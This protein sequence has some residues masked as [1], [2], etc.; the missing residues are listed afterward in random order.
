ME[1]NNTVE[2]NNKV[3]NY[4]RG[5]KAISINF[6]RLEKFNNYLNKTQTYDNDDLI[7]KIKDK[8]M[9]LFNDY[10]FDK[11]QKLKE[12]YQNISNCYFDKIKNFINN[13][14]NNNDEIGIIK[15]YLT[16]NLN[17]LDYIL[18][19]K[20]N[21]LQL[22]YNLYKHRFNTGINIVINRYNECLDKNLYKF[23]NI[24]MSGFIDTLD[25]ILQI[26]S[27]YDTE[28]VEQYTKISLI[29]DEIN[30]EIL[31]QNNSSTNE[32]NSSNNKDNSSNNE[33]NSSNLSHGG[34]GESI[35]DN[36]LYEIKDWINKQNTD[37]KDN[38]DNFI[39]YLNNKL[40]QYISDETERKE[41]IKDIIG[42]ME[43]LI[44]DDTNTTNATNTG[45][46]L[47]TRKKYNR[48]RSITRAVGKRKTTQRKKYFTGKR[49]TTQRKKYFGLSNTKKAMQ[50]IR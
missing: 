39:S 22:F 44:E 2:N 16:Y 31:D 45:G 24:Y 42:D 29:L 43:G 12:T 18:E 14:N 41:F 37:N 33:D 25:H 8:N 20:N 5:L 10:V 30:T 46:K 17:L 38:K 21:R 35:P 11:N 40:E 28:H 23:T 3:E 4:E 47:H 49:K 15:L 34:N 48:H 1:N 32:N 19:Q 27:Y 9:L 7:N 36:I 26:S 50:R 6:M 13:N